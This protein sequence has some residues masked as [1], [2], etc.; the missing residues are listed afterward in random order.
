MPW[1][2]GGQLGCKTDG[3]KEQWGPIVYDIPCQGQALECGANDKEIETAPVRAGPAS[4]ITPALYLGPKNASASLGDANL[5]CA[6]EYLE[7]SKQFCRTGW[8]NG[9][10]KQK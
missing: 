8:R 1:S 5:K 10:A 9:P 3:T 6:P 4:G 2:F 7:A